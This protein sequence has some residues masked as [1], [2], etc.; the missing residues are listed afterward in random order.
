MATSNETAAA[1]AALARERLAELGK[2]ATAEITLADGNQAG[3]G[4]LVRARL[5]ARIDA[6]GQ[7]LAN[8]DMVRVEAQ[9]QRVRA[10]GHVRA[11]DRRR[12]SGRARSSSR[13]P[14]WSRRRTGLCG[15]RP[16]RPG[17]HRRPG[18]LVVGQ[19]T[20]RDQSTSA[21]P[22]PGEE[23]PP[24]GDRR[25]GPGAARPGRARGLRGRPDPARPRDCG[26][27]A[28]HDAAPTRCG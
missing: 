25:A 28:T 6:D 15:Q 5:N 11:A 2:S 27:Q 8:R 10:A 3:P 23:H 20:I 17:P 22:G 14:T 24:R 9:R 18:H 4:D 21:R 12:T 1:L 26:R 16:R 7:T 19:R 13:W